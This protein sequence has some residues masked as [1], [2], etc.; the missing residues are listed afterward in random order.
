VIYHAAPDFWSAYPSL[1]PNI[2]T[3]AD[4]AF[5]LL[6]SDPYHPSLHFKRL[7]DHWSVRVGI[8]HRALGFEVADGILWFWIGS[9]AEYDRLTR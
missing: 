6:T 8:H 5:A 2:Q 1:P 3:V 7:G 4:R 9:H